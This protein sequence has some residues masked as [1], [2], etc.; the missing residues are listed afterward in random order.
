MIGTIINPNDLS[1]LENLNLYK[2]ISLKHEYVDSIFKP[3]FNNEK[4]SEIILSFE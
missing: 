3:K 2:N 1:N 4:V